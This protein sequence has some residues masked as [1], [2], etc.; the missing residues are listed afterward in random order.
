MVQFITTILKFDEMGEKTGWTYI[1]IP[2]AIASKLKPD[3]KKSFRVKGKLDDHAFAGIA[4]IP[5]G[6]GNFIMALKSEL[7]KKIGKNKGATLNVKLQ[8]DE[9]PYEISKELMEC[10]ND[11]P[12][13]LAYFNKLP[14]SHR[15]YYSKWIEGGKTEPTRAKRIAQAVTACSRQMHFGQ[16]MQALKKERDQLHG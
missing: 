7:R 15:N 5:M 9:K 10:L 14:P 16:M 4:L 2:A 13:A 12:K 6:E 8:V 11:E 1:E 3:N